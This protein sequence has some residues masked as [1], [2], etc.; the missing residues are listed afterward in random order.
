MQL[1]DA[2]SD[3]L[4]EP[5]GFTLVEEDDVAFSLRLCREVHRLYNDYQEGDLPS[6]DPV[7]A[8]LMVTVEMLAILSRSVHDGMP[9]MRIMVSAA[10]TREMLAVVFDY[11][12]M[13]R[14]LDL[15]FREL[16]RSIVAQSAQAL[17][18]AVE[19]LHPEPA[20]GAPE[21]A[22]EPTRGG[23]FRRFGRRRR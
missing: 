7:R 10:Q 11:D 19:P 9:A 13:D 5:T 3:V 6:T 4:A 21:A 23:W 2:P 18:K 1:T 20:A 17:P 14:P 12:P 15:E 8:G 22:G 16:Y